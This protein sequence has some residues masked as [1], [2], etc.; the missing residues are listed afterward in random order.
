MR[1][2]N[3]LKAAPLSAT[4]FLAVSE[5]KPRRSIRRTGHRNSTGPFALALDR[6]LR[7]FGH[8]ITIETGRLNLRAEDKR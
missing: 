2:M 1:I 4:C 5:C 6:L 7:I 8:E 3:H